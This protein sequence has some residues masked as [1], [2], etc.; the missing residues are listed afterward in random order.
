MSAFNIFYFPNFA[1]GGIERNFQIWYKTAMS[2]SDGVL[3]VSERKPPICRPKNYAENNVFSILRAMNNV[4]AS[5]LI[6]LIVF[7][8]VLKPLLL[9]L[10][11]SIFLGYKVKLIYRANNDP[12]H[13]YHERS[14][15]RLVAEII[16]VLFL[17]FYNLIIFN[18][19]ELASRCLHYN[20]RQMIINNPVSYN[21]KIHFNTYNDAKFLFVGR[22]SKQKNI[23]NLIK[24]FEIL[25]EKFSLDVVGIEKPATVEYK[26]IRFLGWQEKI[27]YSN[28]THFI[29]PSLYEGSP[30]A[31][32]EGLNNGL[33][34]VTTPFKSGGIELLEAFKM[35][36][37]VSKNFS[38][39]EIIKTVVDSVK[40]YISLYRDTPIDYR[41]EVFQEKL[42]EL[43]K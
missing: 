19:R 16:K 40:E 37:F 32:L 26:N 5:G 12:L 13:W 34:P 33:V 38:S 39:D 11:L 27:D 8:G 24:S 18:S 21:K 14:V 23:A 3:V 35:Q 4:N 20:S 28:Y 1:R 9:K 41:Q 6:N 29:L 31:L 2:V 25:G 10:V 30:N 7:R 17:Q 15:K 22:K 43:F 36:K 42:H